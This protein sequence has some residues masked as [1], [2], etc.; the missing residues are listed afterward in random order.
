MPTV[1]TD[2]T[3]T[4]DVLSGFSTLAEREFTGLHRQARPTGADQ[5]VTP[6]SG[7][8]Q[9]AGTSKL[10]LKGSESVNLQQL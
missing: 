3:Q 2:V 8:G 9:E 10:P 1:Q 4:G 7:Q 6:C 5:E